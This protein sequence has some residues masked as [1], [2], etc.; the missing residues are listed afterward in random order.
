MKP[1]DSPQPPPPGPGREFLRTW[2]GI[3][4]VVAI[5]AAAISVLGMRLVNQPQAGDAPQHRLPPPTTPL[6][7]RIALAEE[8]SRNNATG[9]TPN[10]SLYYIT[11]EPTVEID[12]RAEAIPLLKS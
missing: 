10:T 6:E 7:T 9:S 4:I 11:V 3:I 5:A 2:P 8:H 1:P 12:R